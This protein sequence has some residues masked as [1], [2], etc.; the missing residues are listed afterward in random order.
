MLFKLFLRFEDWP[1]ED[2]LLWSIAEVAGVGFGS[3]F[4]FG[5]DSPRNSQRFLKFYFKSLMTSIGKGFVWQSL[6]EKTVCFFLGSSG[7]MASSDF[8]ASLIRVGEVTKLP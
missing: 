4:V 1:T 8:T 6:S 2:I 3:G 7:I 5:T